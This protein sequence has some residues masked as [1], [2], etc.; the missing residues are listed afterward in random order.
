MIL[1]SRSS[2]TQRQP[3][4]DKGIAIGTTGTSTSTT[5]S[6]SQRPD[7]CINPTATLTQPDPSVPLLPR[8]RTCMQPGDPKMEPTLAD[9]QK[10]VNDLSAKVCK[11]LEDIHTDISAMKTKLQNLEGSVQD[12]SD[13]MLDI[14]NKKLPGLETKL[15]AEID[16][17]K[18]N[19]VASEIYQRKMNL[20][21]YGLPQKPNEDVERVLRE[22]AF[23]LLG[24]SQEE[25]NSISIINSH[26]L[27]KRNA[28]GNA[29]NNAPP[30]IIAKFVYMADRNWLLSAYERKAKAKT[31]QPRGNAENSA[32]NTPRISVRTDLP[33]AL[34]A[35]RSILATKAFQ[36]RKQN[37]LSTKIAVVGTKVLL[38]TKARNA[39]IWQPYK[40]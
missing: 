22:E 8:A 18:D 26:R 33:P 7:L 9:L 35:K 17:L 11:K 24:L 29:T 5:A 3:I 31:A 39:T 38:Y 10:C 27:P 1:R 2:T 16:K 28:D 12:N 36:L 15:M 4:A 19:L 30:V 23:M 21:F 37:N 34:K 6:A 32:I 25:A 20:L 40:E 13:R 14:E